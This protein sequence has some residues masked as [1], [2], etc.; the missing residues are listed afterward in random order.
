MIQVHIFVSFL[1]NLIT[2]YYNATR[3]NNAVK[4]KI[5]ATVLASLVP[6]V[7]AAPVVDP[8]E[9]EAPDP[10]PPD[11]VDPKRTLLLDLST[12]IIITL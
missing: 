6:V 3:A 2:N 7:E 4:H 12:I 5:G 8:P 10:E 1:T 9:P 11:P